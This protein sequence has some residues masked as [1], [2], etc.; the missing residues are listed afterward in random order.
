MSNEPMPGTR[1]KTKRAPQTDHG[2]AYLLDAQVGYVLRQANQRHT[3]IFASLM[4]DGLTPT[5][6][7]AL[8]KLREIGPSSQNLLGRLT[9][10]D[11]ATI[12]GVIDRLTRRGFTQTKPDP[13][14]KRRLLVALTERGTALYDR[15]KPIAEHITAKTL[16]PLTERERAGILALLAKIV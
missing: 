16:E 13:A 3:T 14:D 5:Q 2:E 1:I 11:A 10:M 7:A 9:A 15:A 8:A 12:K 6:W 4:T